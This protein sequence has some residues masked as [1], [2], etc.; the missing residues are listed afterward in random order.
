LVV[1]G[2]DVVCLGL[3]T[4]GLDVVGL[5]VDHVLTQMHLLRSM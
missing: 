4:M 3:V 2:L 5:D 1:V